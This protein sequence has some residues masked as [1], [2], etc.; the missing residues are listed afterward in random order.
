MEESVTG[1]EIY[2]NNLLSAGVGSYFLP[3]GAG[4]VLCG[5]S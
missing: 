1:S 4:S 2:G 5:M 3:G